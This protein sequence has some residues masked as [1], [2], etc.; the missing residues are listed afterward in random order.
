MFLF[1]INH[2]WKAKKD[3]LKTFG[4]NVWKRSF[5]AVSNDARNKVISFSAALNQVIRYQFGRFLIL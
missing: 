1:F 5:V 4:H 2:W 3:F